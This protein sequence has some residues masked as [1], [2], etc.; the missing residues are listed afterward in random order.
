M[1]ACPSVSSIIEDEHY[2][3]HVAESLPE[4]RLQ[5]EEAQSKYARWNISVVKG[6]NQLIRVTGPPCSAL[7]VSLHGTGTHMDK[8][9]VQLSKAEFQI[10][11][12]EGGVPEAVSKRFPDLEETQSQFFDFLE[13]ISQRIIQLMAENPEIHKSWKTKEKK[14]LSNMSG[15]DE[16]KMEL[17]TS[18]F[19]EI[20]TENAMV[21]RFPNGQRYFKLKTS[22]SRLS[23]NNAKNSGKSRITYDAKKLPADHP[24]LQLQSEGL[25][26]TPPLIFDK[27]R[28]LIDLGTNETPVIEA[29]DLVIPT[30][31]FKPY[32]CTTGSVGVRAVYS[33]V[34]LV[35]KIRQGEKYQGRKHD[36]AIF[37]EDDEQTSNKRIGAT[38]EFRE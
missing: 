16:E 28:D 4:T 10:T 24:I 19:M 11:L 17:L 20:A 2:F 35:R 15:T 30:F 13:M 21:K 37:D 27:H 36:F 3:P 18:K 29:G 14:F 33:S 31:Y 26:Y 38:P 6:E 23:T 8:K 9:D 12:R 25:D 5:L 32:D 7:W 34:T 1:A 22:I